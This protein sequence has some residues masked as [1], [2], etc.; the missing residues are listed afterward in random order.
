MS[1]VQYEESASA[2]HLRAGMRHHSRPYMPPHRQSNGI[3][4]M[5]RVMLLA[6]NDFRNFSLPM[7]LTQFL[8]R[9]RRRSE[10]ILAI[11][12]GSARGF[13][14]WANHLSGNSSILYLANTSAKNHMNFLGGISPQNRKRRMI[15]EIG[16]Y[17][18]ISR[19]LGILSRGRRCAI[20]KN[21]RRQSVNR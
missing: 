8:R 19:K 20:D 10:V 7:K 14:L 2:A 18:F 11:T 17:L 1:N 21:R 16:R 5:R 12:I 9:V 6:A 3:I 4:S 13:Y 15:I